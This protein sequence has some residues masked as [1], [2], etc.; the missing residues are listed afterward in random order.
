[1]TEL[2]SMINIGRELAKKLVR[3][4]YE[5]NYQVVFKCLSGTSVCLRGSDLQFG[6][7]QSSGG[8]E[9]RAERV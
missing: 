1:M 8:Q 6:I 4:G 3:M 2:T 7:Q 9:E 5:N